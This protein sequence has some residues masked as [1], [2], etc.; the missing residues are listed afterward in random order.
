M[1]AH[2][3]CRSSAITRASTIATQKAPPAAAA[4][5]QGTTPLLIVLGSA[6]LPG[7]R[8]RWWHVG[9][10]ALGFAGV[11]LADQCRRQDVGSTLDESSV[12]PQ[13]HRRR[14]G[15]LGP[16]FGRLA[17]PARR[18]DRALGMFY[19]ASSA[20]RAC[21]ASLFET[22][23]IA[24]AGEWLAIAGLGFL[25]MGLAIYFWDFGLKRG[26][27]QAL[28]AFSYAE[29]FIGAVLVAVVTHA[30]LSINLLWS[31]AL[32][33]VGAVLASASLWQATP[34]KPLTAPI[35][36]PSNLSTLI[37]LQDA[38]ARLGGKILSALEHEPALT[39]VERHQLERLLAVAERLWD[40]LEAA[41]TRVPAAEYA[42]A[43]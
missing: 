1:A 25:P 13:S 22:W 21:R 34:A 15:A 38:V 16:L 20:C 12:L 35:A 8:L 11:R 30:T 36:A 2:G 6:L 18:A 37:D 10:A 28:G 3:R 31:G 39:P 42:L 7:E 41:D 24:D 40:E 9:G 14:R 32:I 23:V 33:T 43:A 27:I 5:L 19:A 17:H 29:P 4:L 26:D